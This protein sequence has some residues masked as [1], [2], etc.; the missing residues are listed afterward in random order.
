MVFALVSL[1]LLGS[2]V[3][4][5]A[6][7]P[8]PEQRVAGQLALGLAG[9]AWLTAVFFAR[10]VRDG[11]TVVWVV[12]VVAVAL[13]L[14]VGAAQPELSDDVHRYVFE[15]ALVAEG[16]SP[17]AYAPSDPAREAFRETWRATYAR[18]NHPEVSAAYPPL[19]QAAF[20][21]VVAATGA[22]DEG[23]RAVRGLRCFFGLC[24]LGVGALLFAL[25]A[26]RGRPL[27][28]ACVWAWSPLVVL[29]Y[30]G[31]AHL[32]ALALL[33]LVA[34]L[35][36]FVRARD[37]GAGRARRKAGAMA[38]LGAGAGVKL[39]PVV[40]LPFLL[41]DVRRPLQAA[42]VFGATFLVPVLVIGALE[43]GY[44]G[45]G[46]GLGEYALRWESF[47]LVFRWIEAPFDA[48]LSRDGSLFD[49]RRVARAVVGAL[50]LALLAR[51]FFG[52][53]DALRATG[54][55]L[56]AF[57]VL[58]PTLH[59]WY[60]TWILPFLALELSVAWLFLAAA[61]PLLYWP[62][63][64][65][66]AYAEWREPAW[67]WP[68]VAVPFFLLLGFEAWRRRGGRGLA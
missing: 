48:F 57:L 62:L 58:T 1:P 54:L 26:R 67:L 60:L 19:A 52:R 64:E 39:L 36:L 32:D 34:G 40:A 22:R 50:F 11:R 43:G 61:A 47:N 68:A 59:P 23:A 13:R 42:L 33:F 15:G 20:A 45:L 21:G 66:R 14:F 53:V 3:V 27:A 55:A 7:G 10:R 46:S 38:L 44:R 29:E 25:L 2:F 5:L 65:W 28:L 17:F 6:L 63:T 12:G 31:S 24:D 9:L 18:I 16:Q 41:R 49:A 51:N 35:L 37:G 30:A 56:A 8:L 4:L